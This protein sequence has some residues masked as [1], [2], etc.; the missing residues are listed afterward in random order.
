[1]NLAGKHQLL[2]AC[3]ALTAIQELRKLGWGIDESAIRFGLKQVDWR[4]RLE[5]F[6]KEPL[7]LLDVA[8]NAPGM[9]TLID[10]LEELLPNKQIVFVFGVMEDKD[11]G[12]ML[13]EL[14]RKAKF[15]VLTKPEYKR[16]ADPAVLRELVQK[17]GLAY[18]IIPKVR[19]AYLSALDR[20]EM[21]DVVCVTGSHFTVGELLSSLEPNL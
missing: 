11:H 15:I 20:A 8:H 16:A 2:N 17:A 14:G 10:S 7:V 19:Q 18:E 9:K 6:R 12:S 5:I 13:A 21:D 1:L 3:T 4:A